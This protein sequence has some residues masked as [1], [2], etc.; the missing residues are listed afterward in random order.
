MKTALALLASLAAFPQTPGCTYTLQGKPRGSVLVYRNGIFQRQSTYLQSGPALQ[1][2]V[3]KQWSDQ[4]EMSYVYFYA[5]Q[6]PPVPGTTP[7]FRFN[8]YVPTTEYKTCTGNFPPVS[9]TPAAS[10]SWVNPTRLAVT[11]GSAPCTVDAVPNSPTTCTYAVFQQRTDGTVSVVAGY[12]GSAPGSTPEVSWAAIQAEWL[13]QST[14]VANGGTV[15]ASDKA[16]VASVFQHLLASTVYHP[17]SE[18]VAGTCTLDDS[19]VGATDAGFV[20]TTLPGNPVIALWV[21]GCGTSGS[22]P[23][24]QPN[25]INFSGGQKYGYQ[26]LRCVY[27]A[28]GNF[29]GIR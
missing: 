7:P 22:Q 1:T 12:L 28:S 11:G 14:I 13:R 16:A 8:I 20:T 5:I 24:F 17:T 27:D 21:Y 15:S 26:P 18:T 6:S 10:V 23:G 25:G 19:T 4:D 9:P 3:P 2:I 29:T